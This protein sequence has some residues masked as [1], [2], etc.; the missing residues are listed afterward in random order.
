M[1]P[2]AQSKVP[3]PPALS[4]L[5]QSCLLGCRALAMRGKTDMLH[6]DTHSTTTDAT[7]KVSN[8]TAWALLGH[9]AL[10]LCLLMLSVTL[11]SSLFSGEG[12]GMPRKRACS[13]SRR[14]RYNR[15]LRMYALYSLVVTPSTDTMDPAS[16]RTSS[17]VCTG[18]CHVL[19]DNWFGGRVVVL[20]D[21]NSPRVSAKTQS[22]ACTPSA[23][24]SIGAQKQRHTS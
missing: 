22:Q 2:V 13:R 12:E 6:A 23:S 24:H 19:N 10:V 5:L 7:A 17:L 20:V 9:D 8:G 14:S 1:L 3:S 4:C 15:C 21:S 11:S 18:R 16:E